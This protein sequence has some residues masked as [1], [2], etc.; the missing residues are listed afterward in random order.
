[1][2]AQVTG[3]K[4]QLTFAVKHL[5]LAQFLVVC[6]LM[7]YTKESGC[8]FVGWLFREVAKRAAFGLYSFVF[9]CR[10]MRGRH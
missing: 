8:L 1:M 2:H 9:Y 6:P 5:K 4:I 7:Y 10:H 3:Q